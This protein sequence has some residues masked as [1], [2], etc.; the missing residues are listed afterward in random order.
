M[1]HVAPQLQHGDGIVSIWDVTAPCWHTQRDWW[2]WVEDE[3]TVVYVTYSDIISSMLS[4]F[5]HT[6]AAAAASLSVLT[7]RHHHHSND[8]SSH[9]SS[10][11][12]AVGCKHLADS[13]DRQT[14]T[15]VAVTLAQLLIHVIQSF[16]NTA[17]FIYKN[18]WVWITYSLAVAFIDRPQMWP[19]I[20]IP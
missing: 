20:E 7:E 9:Q 17:S 10:P 16:Y 14:D 8:A 4:H 3:W 19:S 12:R 5:R 18:G 13:T 2:A 6:A 11:S 15:A 1:R